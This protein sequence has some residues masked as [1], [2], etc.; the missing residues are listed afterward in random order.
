MEIIVAKVGPHFRQFLSR[1]SK[2]ANTLC[3]LSFLEKFITKEDMEVTCPSCLITR[4]RIIKSGSWYFYPLEDAIQAI[5]IR[6]FLR[7]ARRLPSIKY[8]DVVV[9]QAY[10]KFSKSVCRPTISIELP[11]L[12]TSTI[13][14]REDD[15][16]PG[17]SKDEAYNYV[18]DK[19]AEMLIRENNLER[20]S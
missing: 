20:G 2:K 13:P 9:L 16:G 8:A 3:G 6:A 10:A 12:K 18:A 5:A 7:V 15:I 4:D 14:L 19:L 1:S 11:G 17:K